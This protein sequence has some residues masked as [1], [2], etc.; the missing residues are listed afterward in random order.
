MIAIHWILSGK[1]WR[2]IYKTFVQGRYRWLDRNR[3]YKHLALD[4]LS[5]SKNHI[6]LL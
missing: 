5:Y 2:T 3:G 6:Q 1:V 4:E